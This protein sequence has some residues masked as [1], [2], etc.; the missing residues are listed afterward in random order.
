MDTIKIIFLAKGGEGIKSISLKLA[1]AINSTGL[2]C[3]SFPEYGPER[4]GSYISAYL[5]I[6]DH[7]I[8]SHYPIKKPTIVISTY[9]LQKYQKGVFYLVNSNQNIRNNNIIFLQAKKLAKK[10]NCPFF[11]FVLLGGL[12]TILEKQFNLDIN[13]ILNYFK[14]DLIISKKDFGLLSLGFIKTKQLL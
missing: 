8:L 3:Q 11:N 1:K 5:R 12:L 10:N 6:S 4:S 2:F 13:E 14:K 7:E 9:E